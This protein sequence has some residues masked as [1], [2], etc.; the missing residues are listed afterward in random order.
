MLPPEVPPPTPEPAGNS[1]FATTHWSMVAAAADRESPE[2]RDA[3]SELC[4]A[5]WYPIYV[6]I[7]RQ[8]LSPEESEDLT[9]G[10]FATLL[11][12]DI[13]RG[14]DRT[15]GSFRSFLIACVRHFLAN[16]RDRQKAQKRGGGRTVLSL[17]FPSAESRYRQEGMSGMTAESLYERQWALTLL[18]QVLDRLSEEWQRGG[19]AKM[20][21]ALKC[22]L[23]GES[24]PAGYDEVGA[25]LGMT[26]G[27]VRVAVHRLRRRYRE[28]IR[29]EIA[30]TVR[31]PA[32]V[33]A[34]IQSLFRALG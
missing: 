32:E 18:S 29:E 17:D 15:R 4:T 12:K 8:G 10:F 7:R 26:A 22:F 23:T 6:Y 16:E 5:Y 25:E 27:A 14:I 34:E 30:R 31:D 11:E 20:F 24:G 13:F 21:D 33:D 9:Q 1:R 3:L 2:S 28:L 19:R